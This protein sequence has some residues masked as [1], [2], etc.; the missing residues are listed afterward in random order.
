M[1]T[2]SR[3]NFTFQ[4]SILGPKTIVKT[5]RELEREPGFGNFSSLELVFGIEIC[6]A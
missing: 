3:T 6:L 1:K 5:S 2:S 4:M